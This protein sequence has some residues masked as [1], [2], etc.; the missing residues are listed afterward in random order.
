MEKIPINDLPVQH[1]APVQQV[2]R[3]VALG[4]QRHFGEDK[5]L[6]IQR[7]KSC[8]QNEENSRLEN[9]I[10]PADRLAGNAGWGAGGKFSQRGRRG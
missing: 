8:E 4:Q 9:S 10:A 2:D 1:A 3:L 6:E 5:E 7:S